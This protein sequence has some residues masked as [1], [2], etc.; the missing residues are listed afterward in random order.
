MKPAG[1]IGKTSRMLLII[2]GYVLLALFCIADM[3]T[4]YEF[5]FAYLYLLPVAAITWFVGPWHGL[6]AAFLSGGAWVM[7]EIKST[8]VYSHPTFLFWN[9]ILN[10]ALFLV[11]TIL[12][13]K[14]KDV[15]EQEKNFSRTDSLT[16]VA[17][18]KAFNELATL[19]I[20]R[21]RRY[22]HPLTAA[23]LD[24]DNFKEIDRKFGLDVGNTLLFTVAYTIKKNIREVDTVAR[25][26]GDEFILLLPNTGFEPAQVVLNR[27]NKAIL[28]VMEE[29]KWPVTISIGAASFLNPPDQADEIL[30]ITDGL[31]MEIKKKGGN[32]INAK[33]MTLESKQEPASQDAKP[34]AQDADKTGQE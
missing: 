22:K 12:L 19:D 3:R 17:N 15:L 10:L 29:N 4:S 18:A 8:H 9:G 6:F 20:K 34:G 13:A 30:K 16:Q 1:K 27:I 23:Y 14:I 11:F 2:S 24:L 31:L 21:S 5:P 25:I 26:G 7:A 28:A 33:D 32:G